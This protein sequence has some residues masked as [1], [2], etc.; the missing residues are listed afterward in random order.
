MGDQEKCSWHGKVTFS[1][2]A[3]QGLM[4][5]FLIRRGRV[6]PMLGQFSD[7]H[8]LLSERGVA[9]GSVDGFLFDVGASSIQFDR[10]ERGFSISRNGPLDMRMDGNRYLTLL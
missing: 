9:A 3:G 10:Q 1:N 7:L 4:Y 8:A 5:L 2:S 6:E